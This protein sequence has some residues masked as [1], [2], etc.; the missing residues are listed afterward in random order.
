MAYLLE[1]VCLSLPEETKA[2]QKA[3]H[4]VMGWIGQWL[5][6]ACALEDMVTKPS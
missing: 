4:A 6:V 1:G 3:T 5:T 2:R